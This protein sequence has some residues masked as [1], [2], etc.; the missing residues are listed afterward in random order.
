M[1][2][3]HAYGIAHRDLKPENILLITKN[4]NSDIKIMDFGL[5]KIVAP[6]ET[7]KE[8]F[9]TITYVAPEVLLRRPYNKSVDLWSL[10]VIAHA[11]L[12]GSMPFDGKSEEEIGNMICK[13][14]PTFNN[15]RWNTVSMEAKDFTKRLL[16]KECN[17]RMSLQEARAHGWLKKHHDWFISIEKLNKGS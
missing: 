8:P 7:S 14:E 15:P 10:G 5:S 13:I 12:V 2:Y 17:K 3:L 9:G 6:D 1:E 11:L 16:T 4:E